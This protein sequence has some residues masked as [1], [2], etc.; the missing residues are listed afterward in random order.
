MVR[1][2]EELNNVRIFLGSSTSINNFMVYWGWGT[3]ILRLRI[4]GLVIK[5]TPH[6][7]RTDAWSTWMVC[8]CW[9]SWFIEQSTV[10]ID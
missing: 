7:F 10:E 5:M 3:Q 2:Q 6:C 1:N 4:F 8:L 9:V